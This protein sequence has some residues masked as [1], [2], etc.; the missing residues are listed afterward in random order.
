MPNY[1]KNI[2]I[3]EGDNVQ[4]VFDYIKTPE[5]AEDGLDIPESQRDIIDFNQI[6]PMPPSLMTEE[7]T[8]ATMG[9][10]AIIS[11]DHSQL[12]KH[13][14]RWFQVNEREHKKKEILELG[15]IRKDN[16]EKYGYGSWY[17]W[18][19]NNWGT[20]WN[21]L[22]TCMIDGNAVEFNTAWSHPEPVI[23]A[24]SK[25]FPKNVFKLRFAD[26]D[27][28]NNVGEYVMIDGD[29]VEDNFP[30]VGSNEAMELAIEIQGM[31]DYY[32]FKDGEWI[33]DNEEEYK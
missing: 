6:I 20:K 13:V 15:E 14:N 32:I 12:N 1:V 10:D 21:A 19:V 17:D 9:M 24:L 30:E 5:E 27:M 2:L 28:G 18:S 26:E 11:G 33:W 22:D 31:E 7:S 4:E 8:S 16:I 3:V 25:K 29:M 23:I